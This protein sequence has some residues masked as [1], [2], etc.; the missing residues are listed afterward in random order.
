MTMDYSEAWESGG[1]LAGWPTEQVW[2]VMAAVLALVAFLVWLSYR[3]AVV[4]LSLPK[5]VV[6]LTLRSL[7]ISALLLCLTNPVRIEKTT[8]EPPRPLQGKA[9]GPVGRLAIVVDRSDSMT[10]PDNR[11]L[12]RLD[13]AL[14]AWRRFE[15]AARPVYAEINYYSFAADLQP[16]AS[17]EEALARKGDTARTRLHTALEQLVKKPDGER[18]NAIVVLTDGVDN[19]GQ[20]DVDFIDAART[21]GVV[22]HFI[23][24]ANRE[25]SEPFLRV[26]DLSAPSTVL[27]RSVFLV[28]ATFEAFSRDDRVVPFSLWSGGRRI[29][30]DMLTLTTGSNLVPWSCRVSSDEVGQMDLSLRLEEGPTPRVAART[31]ITVIGL[32]TVSVILYQGALDWGLRYLTEALQ[33]DPSFELLTVVNPA[34]GVSLASSSGST[35]VTGT[36]ASDVSSLAGADCIFLVRPHMRQI[37]KQQQQALVSFVRQGG[38]A[39]FMQPDAASA[40]QF[41]G[42]PL[43]DLLPVVFDDLEG[44]NP[45]PDSRSGSTVSTTMFRQKSNQGNDDGLP[46]KLIPFSLTEAGRASAIFA[47]DGQ[48]NQLFL[49]PKFSE[50][51]PV[52]RL[53]SGAEVL[54]V[55]PT[56]RDPSTGCRHILL[57]TQTFGQGRTAILATDGLWRWKLSEP[58]GKR[59]V[60]TFW[61]QLILTLGRRTVTEHLRFVDQ[62]A[63]VKLGERVTVRLGG[64]DALNKPVI[65]ALAPDG[66][67]GAIEPKQTGEPKAS[68]AIKWNPD[69][70]GQWEF[71]AEV[72][73]DS[74]ASWFTEVVNTAVGESARVPTAIDS[75]RTLAAAT[76]G[77]LLVD[78]L[79]LAWRMER[80]TEQKIALK[81]IVTEQRHLRWNNWLVLG[82]A[83]GAYAL[84]LILRRLWKM[85]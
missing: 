33:T 24:G 65:T 82:I 15:P 47:T 63:Q 34:L 30:G 12:T 13:G 55:H 7:T 31:S 74:P 17:L 67:S 58:S 42:T 43:A 32:K 73:G 62:P 72:E 79:P 46:P 38:C 35:R 66:R 11:G 60:E 53:R 41:K 75:L 61:Q 83:F 40:A 5:R 45:R 78:Q 48:G 14:A 84:E 50:Y 59:V 10:I 76:G 26:R 37:T 39:I 85:L 22:V 69:I 25:R 4:R 27:R 51:F 29:G 70:A 20:S 68:W 28:T 52:A 49:E 16:A 9:S 80:K 36:L 81:P 19:S 71:K 3:Y 44:E 2:P 18:P 1:L 54:A 21:N 6:L 57:A 77:L 56:S 8:A 23:A 64:V